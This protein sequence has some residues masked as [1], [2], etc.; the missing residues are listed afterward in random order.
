MELVPASPLVNIIFNA[1]LLSLPLYFNYPPVTPILHPLSISFRI[2][3][4][5][6]ECVSISRRIKS[7]VLPFGIYARTGVGMHK[8]LERSKTFW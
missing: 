5:Q 6:R 4:I 3:S 2:I 1:S 8:I 7:E